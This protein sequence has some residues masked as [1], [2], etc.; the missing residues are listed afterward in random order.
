MYNN[1]LDSLVIALGELYLGD[2]WHGT[3]T[4]G[5]TT[6]LADTTARSEPDDF[7]NSQNA[8]IYFRT[9][10]N[11]GLTRRISDFVSSTGTSTW[12]TAATA[13]VAGVKYSIHAQYRRPRLVRAIN[14]AIERVRESPI[15]KSSTSIVLATGTYEYPVP[16]GFLYINRIT[17]EDGD[18]QFDG[19]E[20][21]PND[22][23][24]VSFEDG[25]RIRF[26]RFPLADAP[27]GWNYTGFW[28]DNELTSGRRLR[29]EGI[30]YQAVLANDTDICS[31][32]P[33]YVL[34]HAAAILIATS[35]GASPNIAAS[36]SQRASML[37][38]RA[39]EARV[40]HTIRSL[41]VGSKRVA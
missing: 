10:A 18:G 15:R 37:Q 24:G 31:L 4:D 41:P 16:D 28:A 2:C 12:V 27:E 25:Y 34:N 26:H 36:A 3:A 38:R 23:W 11:K 7:F 30:G 13:V 6:T 17:M 29:V 39:D 40:L 8:E 5:S 22:Q 9:G 20:P 35:A 33:D 21:I 14:E 32:N 1:T 19:E